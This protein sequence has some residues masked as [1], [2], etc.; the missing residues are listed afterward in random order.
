[1][2]TSHVRGLLTSRVRYKD[3]LRDPPE[4][5]A[6]LR[7]TFARARDVFVKPGNEAP[8][9]R[10]QT[11]FRYDDRKL[12]PVHHDILKVPLRRGRNSDGY[13]QTDRKHQTEA[14]T[15]S[16]FKR[17]G[18]KTV[19]RWIRHVHVLGATRLDD[20][21]PATRYRNADRGVF[22]AQTRGHRPA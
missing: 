8:R 16:P 5:R 21:S 18:I 9:R 11:A 2:S 10:Q 19:F 6:Q 13:Y 20:L 7:Y 15:A 22:S 17:A 1:A 12:R 14:Q 4:S 3:C